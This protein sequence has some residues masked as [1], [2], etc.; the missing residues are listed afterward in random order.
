M[1]REFGKK[2][3]FGSGQLEYRRDGKKTSVACLE[4][5][6]YYVFRFLLRVVL[7]GVCMRIIISCFN[8]KLLNQTFDKMYSSMWTTAKMNR[9]FSTQCV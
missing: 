5:A 1:H 8:E 2:I 4:D 9:A 7:H 3:Y 6:D